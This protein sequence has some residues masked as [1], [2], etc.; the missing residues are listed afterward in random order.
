MRVWLILGGLLLPSCFA[1][2]A[3][4]AAELAKLHIEV[5]GGA[6]RIAALAAL[7]ATGTVV[8]DGGTVRFTLIAARPNRVRLESS[9]S[10]RSSVQGYDGVEPPW[11]F[12][13]RKKPP[14][15][16]DMDG[17]NAKRLVADSNTTI[18]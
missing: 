10:G 1:H 13:A 9:A 5:V 4:R 15:Y 18:L 17:A 11:E 3:D 6:E 8:M 14:R 2:A 7:R 12:D 16:R